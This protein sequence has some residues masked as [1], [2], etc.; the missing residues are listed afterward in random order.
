MLGIIS[1]VGAFAGTELLRRLNE[2][3]VADRDGLMVTDE[4]FPEVLLHQMSVLDEPSGWECNQEDLLKSLR[5]TLNIFSSA[6]CHQ[7]VF[8]C[9]TYDYLFREAAEDYPQIECFSLPQLTAEYLCDKGVTDYV[10]LSSAAL[11]INSYYQRGN[12]KLSRD[13]QHQVTQ[14]IEWGLRGEASRH[15]T[16]FASF[17]YNL[18]PLPIILGCT[19]LS[20]YSTLLPL[21]MLAQQRVILDSM[22]ILVSSILEKEKI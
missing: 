1:G 22:N 5:Q 20:L 3:A 16:E 6:G 18:S 10:V 11:S 19:E 8:A 12:Q 17:L 4:D 9:N 7:V 21:R 2:G 13:D 14:F 15:G